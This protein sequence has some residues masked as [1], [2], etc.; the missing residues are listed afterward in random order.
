M[1]IL[2]TGGLGYIGSHTV[3]VLI[4]AGHHVICYDN[5]CNSN[6]SVV[7]KIKQITGQSIEFIKGDVRDYRCL[8]QTLKD[9]AIHAVIHF[10]GLKAV[11]ESVDDPMSYYQN[12]V[13][14]SITLLRA[15]KDAGVTNFIFSSS[16]TVYGDPLTLPIDESHPRKAL[17]PYGRSKLQVEDILSD[18]AISDPSFR[19]VVL[20]Y[21]NPVGAHESGLIG[22]DPVGMPNNLMP[23]IASVAAGR[24]DKLNIFGNDYPTTDGTGVRDYIHVMDLARGHLAA[25]GMLEAEINNSRNFWVYNLGTGTGYSVL[26]V[27]SAFEDASKVSIPYQFSPRRPGDAE[28]C[29][30]NAKLA[31]KDLG[32]KAELGI[33]EMC[34]STWNF[35]KNL[36]T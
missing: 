10:A 27:V 16:A 25:L 11:G 14:G 26:E 15:M 13:V 1:N 36:K 24:L 30:A 18:L 5:L 9:Y 17:N 31:E 6:D 23:H 4:E 12:N 32:W 21:F 35:Q 22:E 2:L 34:Q 20:R 33:S 29:Y 8:V 28:V 7:N 3:I 19:C